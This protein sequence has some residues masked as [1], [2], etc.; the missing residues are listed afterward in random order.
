MPKLSSPNARLTRTT[1]EEAPDEIDDAAFV[2]ALHVL[3]QL[4]VELDADEQHDG[5]DEQER[6]HEVDEQQAA[7]DAP[8]VR[9]RVDVPPEE[10]RLHG[11]AE[12]DEIG[13]ASCRER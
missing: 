9:E 6:R 5:P 10:E 13:R 8:V 1:L 12:D 11:P 4:L 3:A 7:E 2:V